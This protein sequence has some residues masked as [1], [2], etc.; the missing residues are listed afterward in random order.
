VEGLFKK[1]LLLKVMGKASF[2]EDRS[3]G[4]WKGKKQGIIEKGRW[5]KKEVLF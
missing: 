5:Q 1:E 3:N 4:K 2:I